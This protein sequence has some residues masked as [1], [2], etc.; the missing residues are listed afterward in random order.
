MHLQAPDDPTPLERMGDL[1][2]FEDRGILDIE[3]AS[4][5]SIEAFYQRFIQEEQPACFETP[6]E[7][8]K[9]SQ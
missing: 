2:G 3:E 4:G 6:I 5:L 8:W 9:V 7:I 1:T